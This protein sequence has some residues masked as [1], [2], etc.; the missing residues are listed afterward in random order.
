M[1]KK[2]VFILLTLISLN[3]FAQKYALDGTDYKIEF[4]FEKFQTNVKAK[5]FVSLSSPEED[6]NSYKDS[7]FVFTVSNKTNEL[8]FDITDI[9]FEDCA[10]IAQEKIAFY[11]SDGVLSLLFCRRDFCCYVINFDFNQMKTTIS[12]LGYLSNIF[13]EI[14]QNEYDVFR[15]SVD[16]ILNYFEKNQ[17]GSL[18]DTVFEYKYNRACDFRSQY[19]II[20]EIKIMKGNL[21]IKS[22]LQ[23]AKRYQSVPANL[24][25]A[26]SRLISELFIKNIEYQTKSFLSEKSSKYYSS[27]LNEFSNTPWCPSI[28]YSD[29]E[30]Y[31]KSSDEPIEGL[32]FGNG[33]Y[34]SEKTY[35]YLQNS[36]AKEIEIEFMESNLKQ[37]VEL[38]DTGYLQFIPLVDVNSKNIK[39]KILSVYEGSKYKDL[40]INCI[41][42]VRRIGF[43]ALDLLDGDR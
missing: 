1:K 35:L 5:Q 16:F 12:K 23:D 20:P 36:R 13:E 22:K 10:L 9:L 25:N 2:I 39:I 27:N 40:C 34:Q 30:I 28:S 26:T 7:T 24:K 42:P 29:E 21:Q 8:T 31:I 43:E 17:I 18:P 6:I 38:A 14:Y 41:L 37:K 33:F 3:A 11:E 4:N 19:E 32:Y 15:I